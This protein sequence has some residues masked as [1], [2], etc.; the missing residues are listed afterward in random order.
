MYIIAGNAILKTV[1]ETNYCINYAFRMFVK[2]I[3]LTKNLFAARIPVD[4]WPS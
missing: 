3:K 2:V 4:I 1:I